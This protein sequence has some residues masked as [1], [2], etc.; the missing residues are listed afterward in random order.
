MGL[1]KDLG[2]LPRLITI[3]SDNNVGINN[4]LPGN[5]RL[6]VSGT[7]RISGELTLNS[8]ISNGQYVYTLPGSTGV[9]ALTSQLHNPVTI[10]SPA[11]GLSL[12]GQVLSL[13]LSGPTTRG[14]LTSEDYNYF[15]DKV[16]G[17]GDQ[18]YLPKYIYSGSGK[19]IGNSQ[20][21]DNGTNVLIGTTTNSGYKLDVNGTGRFS[22]AV[23][24]TDEIFINGSG[25]TNVFFQKSGTNKWIAGYVDS[26]SAFRFSNGSSDVLK[27]SNAGA[28]TFSSSLQASTLK[29]NTATDRGKVN[30]ETSLPWGTKTND[31]LNFT[32]YGYA[33]DVYTE[34]NAGSIKWWSGDQQVVGITA[35]RNIPASG[36]IFDLAFSTNPGGN[37]LTERMR[38]G[39]GGAIGMNTA[40][41][42]SSGVLT[43]QESESLG[44]ALSI[45]NRNSTQQWDFAVDTMAVD[46]KFFGIIDRNNL[47]I[48]MAIAPN[49]N[50]QIGTT[51]DAGYKLDVNGSVRATSLLA[52][53]WVGAQG[54]RIN[55][56]PVTQGVYLG[57]SGTATNDYATI[58]MVGGVTGGCEIDFTSPNVDRK[59]RIGY[60]NYL[61]YMW[62]ETASGTEQMRLT[63]NGEL[64]IGR[65]TGYSAGWQLAVEGNIYAKYDIRADGGA[66]FGGNV[67]IGTTTDNGN[68]LQ[69]AGRM[70]SQNFRKLSLA[71]QTTPQSLGLPIN[72]YSGGSAYLLLI[73]TQFDAG[74]GT[75]AAL[76]MI[77]CGYNG[78]NFEATQI[79]VSNTASGISFSQVN[80]ILHIS[81]NTNW[82]AHIQV[83][84][85]N[86]LF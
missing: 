55:S 29:I 23:S 63:P 66:S 46:D 61:N 42:F 44:A 49:G 13:A 3:S 43:L 73:S 25:N 47:A 48:R 60:N 20:I 81:G 65:T 7:T 41:P 17:N 32:S 27:L 21:Y 53:T 57:N 2:A 19:Q 58:E 18:N 12:S 50:V 70:E 56:A 78:N 51:T 77:R 71:L 5:F 83:I 84:S 67:L 34:H 4:T 6:D 36:D 37:N 39:S 15:F 82:A 86:L 69:V 22:G 80:G 40:S 24:V 1:T 68:K 52:S 31:V 59:G 16:Q 72:A 45:R 9:L 28:A 54:V 30:I 35:W 76:W 26:I 79:S 14:A 62:F 64:L 85:N 74:N 8:T 11:N 10:G 33:G 75:G 38:I